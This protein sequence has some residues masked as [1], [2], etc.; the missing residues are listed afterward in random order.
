M[1]MKKNSGNI[2]NWNIK[3]IQN[4]LSTGFWRKENLRGVR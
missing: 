3:E 1:T 4:M 2:A